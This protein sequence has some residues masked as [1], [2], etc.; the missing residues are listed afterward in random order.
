M[1]YLV[2]L[3]LKKIGI[4]DRASNIKKVTGV[5]P[6]NSH[7]VTYKNIGIWYLHTLMW[8][9][10][11]ETPYFIDRIKKIR[12]K[13]PHYSPAFMNFIP[14][15]Y[16]SLEK[17]ISIL[18]KLDDACLKATQSFFPDELTQTVMLPKLGPYFDLLE[19][20]HQ[21]QQTVDIKLTDG[22]F[23]TLG[24]Q[25]SKKPKDINDLSTLTKR[26]I[27]FLGAFLCQLSKHSLIIDTLLKY[28]DNDEVLTIF[29]ASLK[30]E[31]PLDPMVF[32]EEL[33]EEQLL[34]LTTVITD[35]EK[36]PEHYI[37]S[38]FE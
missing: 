17:S 30:P 29:A 9:N 10:F 27:Q 38:F 32:N 15:F 1:R 20:I 14:L 34:I 3:Y 12:I 28:I 25:F 24:L 23:L 22:I 2:N 7:M 5:D 36:D 19:A 16:E 8:I 31:A 18:K 21:Q 4:L 37:T 35:L 26:D 13:Q 33:I 6:I 11:L